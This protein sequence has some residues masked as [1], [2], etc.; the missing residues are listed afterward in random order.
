MVRTLVLVRHGIAA[1]QG[2][3]A[4]DYERPLTR[5]G[6]RAVERAYPRVFSLM[7]PHEKPVV[8]TSPALRAMQTTNVVLQ[9]TGAAG[10]EVHEYLYDQDLGA[11][12]EELA[13]TEAS[14]LVVVGHAPFMDQ[15]ASRL[16]VHVPVFTTGT[17]CAL[18][19]P[20]Q[21]D[22]AADLLWFVAGP[23][24]GP[25]EEQA[26]AVALTQVA[27]ALREALEQFIANPEDAD[28]LRELRAHMHRLRALVGFLSPWLAG[29]VYRAAEKSL[30]GLEVA[31]ERLRGLDLLAGVTQELMSCGDLSE[32][33]LLPTALAHERALEL[34]GLLRR[35]RR[36]VKTSP[37][38]PAA[39]GSALDALCGSP[40]RRRVEREGLSDRDLA[41]RFDLRMDEADAALFGVDLSRGTAVETARLA[42]REL[43]HAA[44]PLR[45]LLGEERAESLACMADLHRELGSFCDARR[46]RQLAKEC[47]RDPRFKGVRADL[48]VVARDQ[49]EV[50]SATVHGLQLRDSDKD[51]E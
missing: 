42:A 26:V 39:L 50:V 14:C 28:A 31:T 35:I 11:F 41:A 22:R 13:R 8:W 19:L 49:G 6:L 15:V 38:K 23:E 17:V 1:G 30:A 36:S 33:S 32:H 27:E 29:K 18:S 16:G 24:P 34:E 46:N 7:N 51:G 4:S 25:V 20:E 9:A 10:A 12:L 37:T 47:E 45:E 21:E 5:A 43:Y 2:D 3:L 48:G 44:N 40:W